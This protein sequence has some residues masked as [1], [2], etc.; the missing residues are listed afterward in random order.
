MCR[1]PSASPRS[2]GVSLAGSLSRISRYRERRVAFILHNNPCVSV[3]ASVGGGAHLDTLESVA[4][5]MNQMAKPA[6]LWRNPPKSGK[7]LIETIMDR[8]AISEFRWTPI[9][10]IVAKGGALAYSEQR[11]V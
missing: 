3:E 7:E 4:R 5:I 9:E 10:E 8:K 6:I 1:S 11:G 2:A